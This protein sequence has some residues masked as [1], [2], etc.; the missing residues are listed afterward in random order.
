MNRFLA[1]SMLCVSLCL[2]GHASA[3]DEI[4]GYRP[5]PMFEDYGSAK[6]FPVEVK[7]Q[8]SSVNPAQPPHAE[9]ST[10]ISGTPPIPKRRPLKFTASQE[11]LQRVYAERQKANHVI[12]TEDESA[13]KPP[14]PAPNKVVTTSDKPDLAAI[15]GVEPQAGGD[16]TADPLE[17]MITNPTPEEILASIEGMKPEVKDITTRVMANEKPM[18]MVAVRPAE[19][20]INVQRKRKAAQQETSLTAPEPEEGLQNELVI[21]LAFTEDNSD[22]SETDRQLLELKALPLLR[23]RPDLR[24]Q[25]Q[26]FAAAHDEGQGAARRLSLLRAIAIRSFLID[27]DIDPK[28]IDLRALGSQTEIEPFDRADILLLENGKTL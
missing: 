3:Q 12:V 21:S 26:A 10:Q 16:I 1:A 17:G 23:Q 27:R 2:G 22:L 9:P 4:D 7:T 28:R 11:L 5:P 24:V 25:V 6:N 19:E 14:E 8:N 20:L 15:A 18:R 13:A